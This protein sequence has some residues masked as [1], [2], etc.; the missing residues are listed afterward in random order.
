PV[1]VASTLNQQQPFGA[2]VI[3]RIS[4][5]MM[6]P[7]ALGRLRERAHATLAQLTE[8][9]CAE[10]QIDLREIYEVV[11]TGNVTMIQLALGI[12]PEPPPRSRPLRSAAGCAPPTGRS[13]A[14]G[15]STDRSS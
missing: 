13:R 12:D 3:S 14:C 2:D 9:I 1:A 7:E 8:E 10:A 6:D 5:T 15:S 4:A 11:V